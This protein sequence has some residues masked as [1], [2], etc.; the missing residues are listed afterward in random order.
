MNLQEFRDLLTEQ[1][2]IDRKAPRHRMSGPNISQILR[3]ASK[4]FKVPINQID[5]EIIEKTKRQLFRSTNYVLLVY[6]SEVNRK[7]ERPLFDSQMI[8][9]KDLFA[10]KN[11]K[12]FLQVRPDGIYL[13]LIPPVNGGEPATPKEIFFEISELLGTKINKPLIQ[14]I[15]KS[16]QCSYTKVASIEHEPSADARI[17]IT[18]S[19]DGMTAYAIFTRPKPFGAHVQ[20][21]MLY[22]ALKKHGIKFDYTQEELEAISDKPNYKEP[23]VVAEGKKPEK[24]R[25]QYIELYFLNEET[26]PQKDSL[27]ERINFRSQKKLNTVYTGDIIGKIHPP[28]P[29]IPGHDIYGKEIPAEAGVPIEYQIDESIS[30]TKD[31]ELL[32]NLTGEFQFDET[33]HTLRINEILVIDGNLQNDIDFSGSILIKGEVE[34][35]YKIRA[36]GNI[37]IEGHLGRSQ[38]ECGGKLC[39]KSGINGVDAFDRL[40]VNSTGSIYTRYITNVTVNSQAN[41]IVDDGILNSHVY[42]NQYVI[43]KG[44][45]AVINASV[46]YGTKGVYSRSLGSKSEI[47]TFVKTGIPKHVEE[48]IRVLED[49][50]EQALKKIKSLRDSIIN[51]RRQKEILIKSD[52]TKTY[53]IQITQQKI[54]EIEEQITKLEI[55]L[56]KVAKQISKNNNTIEEY[57]KKAFISVQNSL[58]PGVKLSIGTSVMSVNV[59]YKKRLTF[60]LK[61]DDITPD[62]FEII[63]LQNLNL[64]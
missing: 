63:N 30:I 64:E 29:G 10:P 27:N 9:R 26:L 59:T 13:K 40:L 47:N 6:Q 33:A 42:A 3:E 2:E 35:G 31:Q 24:G 46:V 18:T 49:K 58:F 53:A 20:A 32:A 15:C 57:S 54:Q 8:A 7:G 51:Q 56:D 17:N 11:A 36:K 25:D 55:F 52:S 50:K 44:K 5:Y 21:S 12:F 4:V 34:N 19:Q 39:I 48:E 60:R 23:I 43:C 28:S 41:I 16:Q 14:D 1:A 62:S 61:D 45:H 22:N 38:V 37:T